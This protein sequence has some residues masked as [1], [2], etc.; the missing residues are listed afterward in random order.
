[1]NK[2]IKLNTRPD[3]DAILIECPAC[4]A[5]MTLSPEGWAAIICQGCGVELAHPDGDGQG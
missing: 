3:G 5:V 1:M 4:R 2:A